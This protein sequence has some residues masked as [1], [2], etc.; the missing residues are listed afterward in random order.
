[1]DTDNGEACQQPHYG[2]CG[3]RGQTERVGATY[4]LLV[5]HDDVG[6]RRR[7]AR[8]WGSAS[9]SS[10]FTAQPRVTVSKQVW[11]VGVRP[12]AADAVG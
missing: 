10:S 5:G 11:R 7:A 2:W 6:T 4:D 12:R 1:M 3:M 8:T 9:S